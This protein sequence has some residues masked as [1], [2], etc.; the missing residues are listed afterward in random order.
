MVMTPRISRECEHEELRFDFMEPCRDQ[1]GPLFS[2]F[3]S[4]AH[5]SMSLTVME[6]ADSCHVC[7]RCGLHFHRYPAVEVERCSY[8]MSVDPG[9]GRMHLHR[10]ENPSTPT[11][12]FLIFLHTNLSSQAPGQQWWS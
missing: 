4:Y 8:L 6:F 10:A 9:L 3:I 11:P 12:H 5:W 7:F 1:D 2:S